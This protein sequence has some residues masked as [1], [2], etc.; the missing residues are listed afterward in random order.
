MLE[1]LIAVLVLSILVTIVYLCFASV[2]DTA[3]AARANAEVLRFRQF[4]WRSFTTNLASIY[5]DPGCVSAE[6]QFLGA[7]EDGYL[8]PADTLR[9]CTVL[10]MA[11]PKSL[12]GVLRVV[13]YAILDTAEMEEGGTLGEYDIDV[14]QAED[15]GGI[16]LSIREEPLVLESS[17]AE[18]DLEE[19]DIE[20]IERHVPI[21]S[22]DIEFYDGNTDEWLEEWDSIALGRMPWAVHIRIN[23][24]RTDEEMDAINAAGINLDEEPDM[25]LTFALPIGMGVLE[26]FIDANHKREGVFLDEGDKFDLE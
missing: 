24:A 25:D 5:A 4:L 18:A 23:F 6:Y 17:G 21:A 13:E 11:G 20:G 26:Q 8:G 16:V 19:A 15:R 3:E 9:F 12:P 1:L 14:S 2:L 22:M 7:N 10:P